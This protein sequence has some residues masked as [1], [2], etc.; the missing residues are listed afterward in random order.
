MS[1]IINIEEHNKRVDEIESAKAILDGSKPKQPTVFKIT[2][3]A[4]IIFSY[5]SD[6]KISDMIRIHDHNNDNGYQTYHSDLKGFAACIIKAL[7]PIPHELIDSVEV[8]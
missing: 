3:G 2:G 7:G 6:G 5:N 4:R 8:K 1:G